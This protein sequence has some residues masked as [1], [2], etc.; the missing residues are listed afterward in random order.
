[1]SGI[2]GRITFNRV[3]IL[4]ARSRGAV[5]WKLSPHWARHRH[6]ESDSDSVMPSQ[7]RCAPP[8][9]HSSYDCDSG[10]PGGRIASRLDACV[11]TLHWGAPL[12]SGFHCS[13]VPPQIAAAACT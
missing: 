5:S 11:M 3:V 9:D 6:G 10:S 13:T 4:H 8:A 1:M 12:P 2:S 7:R